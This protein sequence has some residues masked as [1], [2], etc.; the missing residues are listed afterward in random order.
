MAR[1]NGDRATATDREAGIVAAYL[2]GAKWSEIEQTFGVG[3]STISHVLRRSGVLPSRQQH[4]LDQES[5]EGALSKLYELI[6]FQ[7]QRIIELEAQLTA[8]TKSDKRKPAK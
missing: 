1:T 8:R 4:R 5:A 7:D 6:K 2:A 3:R